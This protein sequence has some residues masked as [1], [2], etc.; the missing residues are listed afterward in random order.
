M[1]DGWIDNTVHTSVVC[2][3]N[4]TNGGAGC[5]AEKHHRPKGGGGDASLYAQ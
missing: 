1:V 2:G 3:Y 4:A 5:F